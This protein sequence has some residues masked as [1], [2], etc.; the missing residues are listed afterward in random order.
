[1]TN[2]IE[3]WDLARWNDFIQTQEEAYDQYG[4]QVLPNF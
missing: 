2:R 1:V 4:R 3:V